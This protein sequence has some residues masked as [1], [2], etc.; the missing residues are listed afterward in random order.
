MQQSLEF[1]CTHFFSF[2]LSTRGIN[3]CLRCV[4]IGALQSLGSDHVTH[5]PLKSALRGPAFLVFVLARKPLRAFRVCLLTVEKHASRVKP[6]LKITNQLLRYDPP[7]LCAADS[8]RLICE[9]SRSADSGDLN[10]TGRR[11]APLFVS[12]APEEDAGWCRGGVE[13]NESILGPGGVKE[14]SVFT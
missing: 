12:F 10:A 5:L 1:I 14:E 4:E 9:K 7:D 2:F 11:C 3:V 8:S 13:T 6:R